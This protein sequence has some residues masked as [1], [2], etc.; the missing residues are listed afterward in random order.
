MDHL[1]SLNDVTSDDKKRPLFINLCGGELFKNIKIINCAPKRPIIS[2]RYKFHNRNQKTHEKISEY[3]IELK[4]LSQECK[5]GEFLD[6]A[7]RDRLVCGLSN[8]ENLNET[9]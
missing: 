3:I 4:S 7:L 8:E 9:T 5:F 1:F 6:D 2:E